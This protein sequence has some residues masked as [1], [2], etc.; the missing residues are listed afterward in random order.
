MKPEEILEI[1][2]PTGFP[3]GLGGCYVEQTNF[4]CC[5]YD[6]VIFDE[7]DEPES[8]IENDGN[9]IKKIIQYFL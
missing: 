1:I 4:D 7:K 9:F 2:P 3:I 5:V 6:I 8:V